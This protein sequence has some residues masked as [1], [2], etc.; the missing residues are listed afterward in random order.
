VVP[1]DYVAD[2]MDALMHAPG[3]DGRAFHLA[4]PRMQPLLDVYNAFASVA[5]APRVAV[6]LTR[7]LLP[8]AKSP[9]LLAGRLPGASTA[10]E[11][12]AARM[13]IPPSVLPH[14]TFRPG[15]STEKT[16]AVLDGLG[17]APPGVLLLRTRA[18]RL[19]VPPPRP[20]A[21]TP[22]PAGRRARGRTVVVTGASS[23]IGRQTALQVARKG[24][25]PLLV[26]RRT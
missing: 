10:A 8:P 22:A 3:L 17:V 18:L 15:F 13:G 25:I 6:G 21:R 26:A 14:S 19:L 5:G 7:R 9:L 4:H 12:A 16:R 2:A 20:A 23:V 11:L 1:V 24:G